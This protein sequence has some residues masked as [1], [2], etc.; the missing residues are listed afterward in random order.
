MKKVFFGVGAGVAST[1][2]APYFGYDVRESKMYFTLANTVVGFLRTLDPETAHGISMTCCKLGLSPKCGRHHLDKRLQ[3]SVWGL[4]FDSPL[5]LAAG[6]DKQGEAVA[7]LLKMGFGFVEVGG[8]TPKSQPGNP[9]PRMFRLVEDEAIIN[10]F[11]LNSHGAEVVAERLADAKKLQLVGKVGVNL[12]KNTDSDDAAGDYCFG[13][14]T[15]GP[16]VDF[17]VLNVSCPNVKWTSKM[18]SNDVQDIV[19]KVKHARDA[20]SNQPP[21]LLKLGPDMSYESREKMANLAMECEVDGL[22]VS[23]TTSTRLSHLK[24]SHASERGGLSGKPLTLMALDSLRDMYRLTEGKIPLIGVGGITS[25]EEAYERIRAGASLIQ[26]YT[27]LVYE[28]PG[29]VREINSDL[30]K[31]IE[32]DGFQNIHQAVGA[33]VRCK[34]RKDRDLKA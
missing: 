22:I 7:N 18:S 23:N 17:I 13:V 14:E 21:L 2:I 3:T 25:G 28:G 9:K 20:L 19:M 27:A 34:K 4:N 33:D 11:G 12:A 29:L 15:L 8:V 24:S 31:F 32:R 16:H 1:G 10:R 30:M 6:Y 26:I 5:G